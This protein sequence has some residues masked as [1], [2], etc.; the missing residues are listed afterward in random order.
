MAGCKGVIMANSSFSWWGAFLSNGKVIAPS[1][2]FTNGTSIKLL[3]EWKT[4]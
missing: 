4:I 1:K 2:W 3:K